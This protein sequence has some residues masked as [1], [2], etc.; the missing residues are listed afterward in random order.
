MTLSDLP[1]PQSVKIF[2]VVVNAFRA[3]PRL[4]GVVDVWSVWDG[5]GPEDAAA[6]PT[7]KVALRLSPEGDPESWFS[8][9]LTNAPLRVWVETSVPGA[10]WD[11]SAALWACIAGGAVAPDGVTPLPSVL[12]PGDK[13]LYLALSALGAVSYRASQPAYAEL[14]QAG[15]V[16]LVGAGCIEVITHIRTV[17]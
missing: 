13:S 3:D 1:V 14:R 6:P 10:N 17:V 8:A 9:N 11:L 7:D 15:G 5:T 4:Q 2:R 12:F 16:S